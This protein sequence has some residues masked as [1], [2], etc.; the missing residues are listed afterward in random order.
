MSLTEGQLYRDNVPHG[1]NVLAY[2]NWTNALHDAITATADASMVMYVSGIDFV[3]DDAASVDTEYFTIADSDDEIED[4]V[5]DDVMKLITHLDKQTIQF[6]KVDATNEAIVGE[7]RFAPPVKVAA[8][9]TFTITPSA[10]F[11]MTDGVLG[12]HMLVRGWQD[13]VENA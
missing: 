6:M 12:L 2:G 10:S 3:I 1:D 5:I 11:V 7:I 9:S 8:A 4:I 13:S